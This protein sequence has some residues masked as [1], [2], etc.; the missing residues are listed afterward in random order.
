MDSLFYVNLP[1]VNFAFNSDQGAGR[2]EGHTV[3]SC[4]G[5][6]QYLGFAHVLSQ[7]RFPETVIDFV[8]S[9][10]VQV[11]T[12]QKNAGTTNFFRQT[13]CVEYGTWSTDEVLVEG[14]QFNLEGVGSYEFLVRFGYLVHN[15]YELR[16]QLLS[17]VLAKVTVLARQL[18]RLTL[19]RS[20][21]H[22]LTE[23]TAYCLNGAKTVGSRVSAWHVS[24]KDLVSN[25]VG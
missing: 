7:E 11:F 17:P 3:L 4:T 10:M 18:V 20:K 12:F 1:H 19:N 9:C 24:G 22:F 2:G 14:V 23:L 13:A 5:F 25:A 16:R 6:S 8:S 15:F 21:P